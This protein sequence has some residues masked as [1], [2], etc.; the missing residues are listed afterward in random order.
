MPK[1]KLLI[2]EYIKFINDFGKRHEM[3][4][5]D[6]R[7]VVFDYEWANRKFPERTGPVPGLGGG[8]DD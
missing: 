3:N 4:H 5:W 7:K 8:S 2:D 1:D 6:V